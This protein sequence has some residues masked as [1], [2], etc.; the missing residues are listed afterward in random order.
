MTNQQIIDTGFLIDFIVLGLVKKRSKISVDDCINWSLA[1]TS[2]SNEEDFSKLVS[3]STD[4]I[5]AT[6]LQAPKSTDAEKLS[7][8]LVSLLDAARESKL[9]P[10]LVENV[11]K[12]GESVVKSTTKE[13]LDDLVDMFKAAGFHTEVHKIDSKDLDGGIEA[14]IAAGIKKSK[15]VL[16]KKEYTSEDK[17][18]TLP[19]KEVEKL[20]N[21]E[22]GSGCCSCQPAEAYTEK[23]I[24]DGLADVHVE[25]FIPQRK[26]ELSVGCY[27][28]VIFVDSLDMINYSLDYGQESGTVTF[29]ASGSRT[30]VFV[31]NL[32][33][34]KEALDRALDLLA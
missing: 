26:I 30:D 15:H 16:G 5:A 8:E 4:I 33:L 22:C 19:D 18:S 23:T 6:D 27:M 17:D 25:V 13:F 12:Y 1:L 9:F 10:N 31:E 34:T 28:H 29:L 20:N 32:K 24:N 3:L 2:V 11:N 21:S 7:K 14:A